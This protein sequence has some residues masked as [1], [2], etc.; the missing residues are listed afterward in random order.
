MTP[1]AD[2]AV[3]SWF[4]RFSARSAVAR[5]HGPRLSSLAPEIL[6]YYNRGREDG[7]LRDGVQR[8]D[9]GA[10]RTS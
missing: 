10:P 9:C 8:L 2:S 4:S 3:S 6:D 7:R 1:T 5:D